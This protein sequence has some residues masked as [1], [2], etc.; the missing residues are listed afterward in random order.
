[1][2]TDV[3]DLD[4][5][6]NS[7]ARRNLE[8]RQYNWDTN[9]SSNQIAWWAGAPAETDAR[10]FRTWQRV[11]VALQTALRASVPEMFFR[12]DAA[13]YEDRKAGYQMVV[14]EACRVCYGRP[15]TEFTYD[16]ADA[17][18][19]PAALRSIRQTVHA[20]LDTVSRRLFELGRSRAARR[21]LPVFDEDVL[22][23]VRKRPRRL[24]GLLACEA[25]LINAVIDW[26]TI[27]R[28]P[29]EKRFARIVV[30]SARV[31]GVDA[32]ELR[33]LVLREAARVL[34]AK[35]TDGI[36][37]NSPE[38]GLDRGV[39]ENRDTGAARRPDVRIGG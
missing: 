36:F 37:T 39:L 25:R 29:A 30:K 17:A 11:S 12:E 20:V 2:F 6:Y 9:M 5:I 35:A 21:Y 7:C 38:D 1:M 18:M 34:A 33:E 3:F 16:V 26:G 8:S 15:S 19:L 22:R 23:A 27:Q 4:R 13:R 28:A 10:Y 32:Q 31:Y 24:I 14:Y